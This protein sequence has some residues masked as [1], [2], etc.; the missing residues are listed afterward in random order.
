MHGLDE[1]QTIYEQLVAWRRDFHRYP[2]VG[3]ALNRTAEKVAHALREMGYMVQEGIATTGVVGLLE[4]GSGPTVMVRADMDALPIQEETGLPF[5]SQNPGTMHACGHDAHTAM[6]LGVAELMM[7]TRDTWRGTLKLVFQ[8]GEEGLNGAAIM[9][10]EGVLENPRPDYVLVLHVWSD[11]STG[12]VS[13]TAGPVMAGA[14]SWQA[15]ITGKGGHAAHPEE[16][17]DSI[18]TAAMVVTALQTIVSRNVGAQETAVVTVSMLQGGEAFNILPDQVLL[19]GTVRTY[20]PTVR[21]TILQRMHQI[22]EGTA[23][24][25]GAK[26][27]VTVEELG[28]A[29]VN[30]PAT[31]EIIQQA[32]RGTLGADALNIGLRTMASEDAAYF[33]REIPGC[34]FFVGCTP[35]DQPPTPHHNPHF[36][37][38][39]TALPIGVSVMMA[40]LRKLMPPEGA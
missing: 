17:V 30:D 8:P 12:T 9:V 13:A 24:M 37:I 31:T 15:V 33:L 35:E 2:E 27:E 36:M 3:L 4:N 20:D 34:Y 7:R 39:E 28:P 21:K 5:A 22:I 23:Q 19:K 14:D 29:L 32:I 10:D 1:A 25:M 40:A 18:V 6:G 11:L 38:N 26:A 16:T